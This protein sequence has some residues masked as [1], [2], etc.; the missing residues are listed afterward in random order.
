MEPELGYAYPER[1]ADFDISQVVDLVKGVH[2]RISAPTSPAQE[3]GHGDIERK[4]VHEVPVHEVPVHEVPVLEVPWRG[5]RCTAR[6]GSR[7]RGRRVW[8]YDAALLANDRAA[9]DGAVP[10]GT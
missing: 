10:E 2:A 1:S 3:A 6:P 7:R 8:R 9:L 5:C 4:P